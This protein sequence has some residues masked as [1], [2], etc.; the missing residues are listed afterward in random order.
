MP[1]LA[2][3][4]ALL[5]ASFVSGSS[6]SQLATAAHPGPNGP[7]AFSHVDGAIIIA[8]PG[9]TQPSQWTEVIF[10]PTGTTVQL[11][12]PS[13][14]P[15]GRWVA[16]LL[17]GPFDRELWLYD[18]TTGNRVRGD[19]GGAGPPSWTPDATTI[20]Y[21]VTDGSDLL[22]KV[23]TVNV[24]DASTNVLA[25]IPTGETAMA[26]AGDQV[27]YW[28][29]VDDVLGLLDVETGEQRVVFE[30]GTDGIIVGQTLR[31]TVPGSVPARPE[32]NVV[33]ANWAPDSQSFVFS[34]GF[35]DQDVEN[36]GF[37]CTMN[38]DGTDAQVITGS[39]FSG[40]A[41]SGAFTP[42]G[43]E[44]IFS[45]F[46][47]T[48]PR[49]FIMPSTGMNADASNVTQITN[50]GIAASH[51][52][53]DVGVPLG[54]TPATPAATSLPLDDVESL[55]PARLLETRTVPGA[56]TTDGE[57]AGDGPVDAGTF[58]ELDVL[59]RGGVPGGG[60]ESV[61]LNI[62]AVGPST[63][64]FLTMY[65]C[66]T[67]PLA[68]SLN[69]EAGSN[70]ASEVIAKVSPA[71]TVCIYT[72]RTSH[73]LADVTGYV[74]SGAGLTS[75]TP[76]R[77]LES[78]TGADARTIDGEFQGIGKVPQETF[79][80]LQ[81]TGRGGVPPTGV[82][83]AVLNVT[84]IGADSGGFLTVY[85][86]GIR[87]LAS[88]LNYRA[89]NNVANEV[90]AKLTTD[91]RV[92]VYT[93][94]TSHL[95]VDVTGYITTNSDV[96]SVTPARLLETRSG[97]GND[98]IDDRF[99]GDGQVAARQTL[100]LDVAGRGGVPLGADSVVLNVTAVGSDQKG[101]FTVY[102]C[103]TLPLASS[104]SYETNTATANEVIA[105]L[106]SGGKVCIFTQSRTHMIVDVTGY[107]S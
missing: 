54:T 81:V 4:G 56:E 18:R 19:G 45:A 57:F 8:Q 29:D 69:Y 100:E 88:A 83:S 102:P 90:I 67:R 106:S 50:D 6:P 74:P 97:A 23:V 52:H 76:A 9:Q 63:R 35:V 25:T 24:E 72:H 39:Q 5:A 49:L 22:R 36:N 107:V 27:L 105:K 40:N 37:L 68:S 77:L 11:T 86:C 38:S 80:E 13:I 20:V 28:D 92:C 31:S 15:D 30:S 33:A 98:T 104:L 89:N 44:I 34:C 55:T 84:A 93:R 91:G 48:A 2:I 64:G 26:P 94:S 73:L 78:R 99:E 10:P 85:A 14:S 3:A 75:V 62:T 16:Y 17:E 65:P 46:P 79:V 95:A 101:F 51:T 87:P 42:Q 1:K 60:V 71:G 21:S 58:V 41:L 47:G 66:G 59:G 96:T 7:V 103:G 82:A 12:S 43:D 61:V 32:V 70:R 53:P